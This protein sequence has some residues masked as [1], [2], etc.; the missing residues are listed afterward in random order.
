MSKKAI[1]TTVFVLLLFSVGIAMAFDFGLRIGTDPNPKPVIPWNSDYSIGLIH[2]PIIM[3][4]PPAQTF[5]Q[6]ILN[7]FTLPVIEQLPSDDAWI[8]TPGATGYGN[9]P[10]RQPMKVYV[11]E[12][13]SYF[14]YEMQQ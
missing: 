6:N 12:P 4:D 10:F 11:N 1:I 2:G 8:F 9:E 7:C 14:Y 13:N 5:G 3:H